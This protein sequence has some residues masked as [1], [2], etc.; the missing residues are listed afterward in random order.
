M[1]DNFVI[2]T[3]NFG[4]TSTVPTDRFGDFEP[5]RISAKVWSWLARRV[6]RDEASAELRPVRAI[7][8]R[9]KGQYRLYFAD[10]Y[11]LTLTLRDRPKF[12]TQRL[13]A[14]LE[15]GAEYWPIRTA[16]SFVYSDGRERLFMSKNQSYYDP[17]PGLQ[18]GGHRYVY[19][20]DAG[21]SFDGT[22]IVTYI[23]FQWNAIGSPWQN[24]KF[25]MFALYGSSFGYSD[26]NVSR[27]SDYEDALDPGSNVEAL[28]F[29]YTTD[30]PSLI[31]R[32]AR[33]TC[34]L[35][36][37]GYEVA[38]RVDRTSSTQA[39]MMISAIAMNVSGRGD[40]RGHTRNR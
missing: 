30:T 15:V 17:I 38:V 20:L 8:V 33:T 11:V 36:I 34:S 5:G 26:M 22:P 18:D 39:P 9:N 1:G 23:V 40:T 31:P 27:Y 35:G 28:S 3:N 21:R 13:A 37:E 7:P 14:S 2:Y 29:G 25:D 10:G 32:P 19:E 24:K 12:T 6:Q 4:I 16:C